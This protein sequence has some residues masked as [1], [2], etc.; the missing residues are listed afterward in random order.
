VNVRFLQRRQ[1]K[2]N[3]IFVFRSTGVAVSVQ[4][5]LLRQREQKFPV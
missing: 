3:L 4:D 2:I 5:H 1:S